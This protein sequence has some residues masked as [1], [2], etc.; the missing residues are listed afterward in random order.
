MQLAVFDD[1]DHLWNA[2]A[3]C[4]EAYLADLAS[5]MLLTPSPGALGV[6]AGAPPVRTDSGFLL[7]FH[8]RRADASYDSPEQSHGTPTSTRSGFTISPPCP[9]LQC[10]LQGPAETGPKG[11]SA[12]VK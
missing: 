6:G 9:P 1:L 11:P 7:F 12:L 2:T 8:E 5:H 10:A 3:D 4:W